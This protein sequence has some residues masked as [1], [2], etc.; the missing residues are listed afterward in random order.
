LYSIATSGFSPSTVNLGIN[1]SE[2]LPT[3]LSGVEVTF[4]GVPAAILSTAP[5]QIIVAAPQ[6]LPILSDARPGEVERSRYNETVF[7]SVQLLY[8]GVPSNTVSM[9]VSK[10]L[11]GLLTLDAL[12]PVYHADYADANARNQ[13]GTLNSATN[14]APAGSTITLFTTGV[15]ATNP[16]VAPGSI[17]LSPGVSPITPLYSSWE[18]AGPGIGEAAVPLVVSDVPGFVSAVFQVQIP[19]PTAIQ[20]L[21][22]TDLGNGIM[23]VVVALQLGVL[24]VDVTPPVSNLVAVYVH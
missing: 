20:N 10:S 2:N 12:N 9:P 13:D 1:P 14:P 3:Q 4:D 17:A 5:G 22:G 8:N 18:T 23:R 19:V 6:N 7:T 11:P 21:P 15:G 24:V 16:P